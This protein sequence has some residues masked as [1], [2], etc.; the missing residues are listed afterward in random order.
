MTGPELA[1]FIMYYIVIGAMIA[2]AT[3]ASEKS[4]LPWIHTQRPI[5]NMPDERR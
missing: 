4:Q 3:I 1:P 5:A 2:E